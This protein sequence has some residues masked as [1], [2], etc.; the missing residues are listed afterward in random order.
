MCSCLLEVVDDELVLAKD[1]LADSSP[2]EIMCKSLVGNIGCESTLNQ[3]GGALK[4]TNNMLPAR[5]FGAEFSREATM[6][7]RFLMIL[8]LP[9]DISAAKQE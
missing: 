6:S 9:Y 3:R 7:N 5:E 8:L 2:V 4:G 1:S